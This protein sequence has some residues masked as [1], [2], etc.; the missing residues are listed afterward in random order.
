MLQV[1][2]SEELKAKQTLT[3]NWSTAEKKNTDT[4]IVDCVFVFYFYF[5]PGDELYFG[6]K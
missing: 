1:T 5:K 3:G 2:K 6:N 4:H